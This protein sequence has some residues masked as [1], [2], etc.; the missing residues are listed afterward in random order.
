MGFNGWVCLNLAI[1]RVIATINR[2]I[3]SATHHFCNHSQSPSMPWSSNPHIL[4]PIWPLHTMC[5]SL[6]SLPRK[7][8]LISGLPWDHDNWWHWLLSTW[9]AR[10]GCQFFIN[11]DR[12]QDI[13]INRATTRIVIFSVC[14]NLL[15]CTGP[16]VSPEAKFRVPGAGWNLLS[17]RNF[18]L[19]PMMSDSYSAEKAKVQAKEIWL[20]SNVLIM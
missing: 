15:S 13:S 4:W 8:T 18:A 2:V 6:Y 10:T 17:R 19:L 12:F 20:M 9:R 16:V 7:G 1:N 3:T 14:L 5:F 11:L